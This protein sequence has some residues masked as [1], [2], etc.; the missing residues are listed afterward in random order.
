MRRTTWIIVTLIA[1][2][3]AA[4]TGWTFLR[5]D[6][7][8]KADTFM[9]PVLPDGADPFMTKHDD[10]Y[11]YTQTTGSNVTL[12][13]TDAPTQV[14]SA[15]S[16]VI[17][18]P[19]KGERDIWAPEVHFLNG[20]WYVY[21]AAVLPG[22]NH[23]MYVLESATADPF[24]EYMEKGVIEDDTGKW[25]IDGTVLSN[26]GKLY[27]VW[28]GW[29]GNDNVSQHLY[30]AEMS[31]PTTISSKRVELSRP[32]F[33]WEMFGAP[34]SINEGPQILTKG[35]HV[36]IV[37]SAS[38]SWTDF[39]Q[40]GLLST[41]R[42]Q[43]MLD[44]DA[45]TKREEPVFTSSGDVFGPGHA[46]FITSPDGEEDWIVYHAA[47]AKGSGWTRNVRMQPFTWQDGFPVFKKPLDTDQALSLPS[48]EENSLLVEPGTST[49][50]PDQPLQLR[51]PIP[52]SGRY[53]LVVHL[54]NKEEVPLTLI[55][56]DKETRSLAL[57]N[58]GQTAT[59]NIVLFNGQSFD[60]G[61]ASLTLKSARACELT[62]IELRKVK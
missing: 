62:R 21:Y 1:I 16:K 44:P 7:V 4:F 9:N 34:P 30:I 37:Y 58:K 28:S 19:S 43:D 40:L 53:Q 10:E 20:R 25:A 55:A 26:D 33:T 49:L 36:H 23:K 12:W 31:D 32:T 57:P 5:T 61:T 39:Y 56:N 2:A 52:A 13:R 6:P 46:S 54:K 59:Q 47:R 41:T 17:W 24:S 11:V 48:G 3:A 29:E 22:E 8:T 18:Q 45:W 14:G 50:A 42:D 27:F 38:G 60:K 15:E 51:L 35:E